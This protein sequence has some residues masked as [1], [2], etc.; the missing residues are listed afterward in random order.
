ME[1]TLSRP[2]LHRRPT[3]DH[4]TLPTRCEAMAHPALTDPMARRLTDEATVSWHDPAAQE[5]TPIPQ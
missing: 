1:R 4:E 3:R 5:Q 2:R